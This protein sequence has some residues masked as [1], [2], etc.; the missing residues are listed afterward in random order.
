MRDRIN[1]HR[2]LIGA[3]LLAASALAAPLSLAPR[4]TVAQAAG[5][6]A[7]EGALLIPGDGPP[8]ESSVIIVEGDRI[9]AAGR[10]GEVPVPPGATRVDLAGKTVMPV[11]IDTHKH[12]SGNRDT[13]VAQLRQLASFGVGAVMSLGQDTSDAAF[14]VK[15]E[16]PPGAARLFSAGRGITMPEPGR[17]EAPYW[18]NDAEEGRRAVREQAV[19]GAD[20]IKI[21]VD[22]RGGQYRKMPPDVYAAIIDEAHR[23]GIP[24]AA[25]IFALEDAKGLLKAGIDVFAHGIRDRDVDDEAIALFRERPHVF[26]VPNL[27]DRGVAVDMS[28][29]EGSVTAEELAKIQSEYK[30]D[31]G[32][33]EFFGVQARNLERLHAAGVRVA[34]GTDGGVLWEPHVELENMVAAG[35]SPAEVIRAATATSAALLGLDDAGT[36]APGRRADFIVLDANP[37]EDITHTRRISAVYLGGAAI[38]RSRAVR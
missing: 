19:R 20:F 21:W 4:V 9:T 25:H 35:L 3:C 12:L 1:T 33:Q 36:L 13:L 16:P 37:L 26:L 11:L 22:D 10:R 6:T 27:P 24:V 14:Q 38:D 31:P 30:D 2:R 17:S 28:W 15:H 32:A 7:F 34:F 8:V 29:L 18:I 5:V 23:H